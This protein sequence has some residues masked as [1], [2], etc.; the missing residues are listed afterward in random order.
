[1]HISLDQLIVWLLVGATAGSLVGLVVKRN[2]QGF[3]WLGNLSIGLAGA[4]V[5]GLLFRL[6][7]I[8]LGLGVIAISLEDVVAALVGA[9]VCLLALRG[10]QKLG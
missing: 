10:F 8:D 3:G 7:R 5:G 9:I 6:L 4:F 2:K 1:M